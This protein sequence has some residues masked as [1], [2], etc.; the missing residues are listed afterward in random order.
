MLLRI[1]LKGVETLVQVYKI[2]EIKLNQN[3]LHFRTAIAE[4]EQPLMLSCLSTAKREDNGVGANTE[5]FSAIPWPLPE[6]KLV[7]E[8]GDTHT[9]S[10]MMYVYIHTYYIMYTYTHT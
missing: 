3:F 4:F 9:H 1:N 7:R 6:P 2:L 5:R 10:C 8:K